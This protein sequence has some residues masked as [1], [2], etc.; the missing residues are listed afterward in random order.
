M[1]KDNDGTTYL[2]DKLTN[3]TAFNNKV[4]GLGQATFDS[5]FTSTSMLIVAKV[6]LKRGFNRLMRIFSS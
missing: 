3:I 6:G 1:L 5:T 2:T 4:D